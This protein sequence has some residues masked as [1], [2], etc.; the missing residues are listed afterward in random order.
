LVVGTAISFTGRFWLLGERLSHFRVYWVLGAGF[1]AFWALLERQRTLILE[2]IVVASLHA[3]PVSKLFWP[4]KI[5]A[6]VTQA[7]SVATRVVCANLFARNRRLPEA[8][9]SIQQLQADVVVLI[10]VT[11]AMGPALQGILAEYP[12]RLQQGSGIWLL[13]KHSLR[14]A[15]LTRGDPNASPFVEATIQ[16]PTTLLRLVATHPKTPRTWQ[17]VQQQRAEIPY[18]K[19]S[20]YRDSLARHCLLIGDFNT[21]PFSAGFQDILATTFLEYAGQGLPYEVTWGP[22]LPQEPLLPYLGVPIDLAFV[23]SEI[24][25]Q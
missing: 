20:L 3:W 18:W 8:I 1:L 4:R 24:K 22:R 13:S 16:L 6:E 17:R 19:D 14:L 12:H 5:A 9:S 15:S 23:S 10:E 25:V 11:D 21:T 2:A 7:Q